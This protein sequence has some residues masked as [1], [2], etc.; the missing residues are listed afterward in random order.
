MRGGR[1]KKKREKKEKKKGEK[2]RKIE[3]ALHGKAQND[4]ARLTHTSEAGDASEEQ[5]TAV[6]DCGMGR[7]HKPC[8]C[9]RRQV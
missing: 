6:V 5:I 3:R 9:L 7:R 1:K 4:G 2:N 8:S